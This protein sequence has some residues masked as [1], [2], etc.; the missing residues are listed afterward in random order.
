MND[1][2]VVEK[3]QTFED[4]WRFP[5]CDL[6][7]YRYNK[8]KK[9]YFFKQKQARL[10]WPNNFYDDSLASPNGTYLKKFGDFEMR[11]SIDSESVLERQ[12]GTGW[13]YIGT[14]HNFN[15]YTL[16]ERKGIKF[17][18]PANI[19]MIQDI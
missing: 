11:V 13:R 15:H 17:V 14:L 18:I 10:W 7:I 3:M 2:E 9:K 5:F 16:E 1:S 6:F 19:S 8:S 12:M 4:P